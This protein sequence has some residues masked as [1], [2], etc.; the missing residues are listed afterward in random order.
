[1]NHHIAFFT[2][3]INEL[4]KITIVILLQSIIGA[5]RGKFNPLFDYCVKC[6][7]PLR[8]DL[9]TDSKHVGK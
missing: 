9:R 2:P 5:L 4:T 3:I 7:K 6:S 8:F 1:M